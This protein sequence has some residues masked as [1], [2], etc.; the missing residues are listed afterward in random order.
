[1]SNSKRESINHNLR[2]KKA[3]VNPKRLVIELVRSIN[4]FARELDLHQPA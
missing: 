1:M 3:L 4:R 2:L